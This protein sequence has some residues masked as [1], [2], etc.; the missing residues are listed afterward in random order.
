LK[1]LRIPNR[2]SEQGAVGRREIALGGLPKPE[3]GIIKKM[4]TR[5]VGEVVW[6]PQRRR[7]DHLRGPE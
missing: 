5:A 2:R 7:E 4:P 6:L 3:L 1:P